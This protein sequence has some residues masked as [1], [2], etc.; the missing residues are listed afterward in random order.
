MKKVKFKIPNWQDQVVLPKLVHD[1]GS[2]IGG[3]S[4]VSERGPKGATMIWHD[5]KMTQEGS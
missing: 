4:D 2:H 1:D 5:K 3:D